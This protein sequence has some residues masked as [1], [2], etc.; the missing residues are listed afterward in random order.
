MQPPKYCPY[1]GEPVSGRETAAI[2]TWCRKYSQQ[3]LSGRIELGESLREAVARELEE[4]IGLG[5]DPED[6][7]YPLGRD[8]YSQT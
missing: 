8:L 3:S 4:E 6:L 7:T 5:V 1:C 2:A